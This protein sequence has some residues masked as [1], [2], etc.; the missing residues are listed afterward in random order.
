MTIRLTTI[1]RLAT[2]TVIAAATTLGC[3]AKADQPS[4]PENGPQTTTVVVSYD[5]LLNQKAVTRQANLH[6]GDT[7]QVS[8]GS[9]AST[10]FQWAPDMT[11]SND[12]VLAQ[13]G[14]EAVA[15]SG[16]PG[17]AGSEVWALQAIGLG[18]TT[19]STT[20]S[21]PWEGGEKNTWTFTADVTVS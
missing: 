19:V 13:T 2:L 17:A 14:H 6:V 1:I 3:T 7:L 4:G 5:D 21:R 15:G 18:T 9:N 20:Y 10:G 12:R 16:A 11:I 8:L